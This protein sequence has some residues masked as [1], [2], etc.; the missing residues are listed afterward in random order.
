METENFWDILYAHNGQRVLITLYA[1][2]EDT[3]TF[4]GIADVEVDGPAP[5]M[6]FPHE[7]NL[8]LWLDG[9]AEDHGLLNVVHHEESELTELPRFALR[10]PIYYEDLLV[11]VVQDG[12]AVQVWP[13]VKG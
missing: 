10:M 13:V 8:Y 9:L 7:G 5:S 3:F 12:R 4:D 6:N 2:E 11:R 1:R